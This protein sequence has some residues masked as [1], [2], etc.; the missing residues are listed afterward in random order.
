MKRQLI[1]GITSALM[2][3]GLAACGNNEA[4]S[5]NSTSSS[6]QKEWDGTMPTVEEKGEKTKLKF[7]DSGAP[8]DLKVQVVA[9]GSGATVEKTDTVIADYVG[10]VWGKDESFDSSFKRGAPTGFLLEKVIAGWT[11]GLAGQK[12]GSKVILV[13]PPDKGYGASGG[14][15]AAGIGADDVIA[16]YVEIK[17]AYGKDKGGDPHAKPETPLDQLPVEISGELGS[18][19]SVKV[20]AGQPQPTQRQL[21]VIARGS[22]EP[23]KD[24]G[25]TVYLQYGMSLWDNSTGEST[26]GITGPQAIPVTAGSPFELL[27]D[28]PVGSRVLITQPASEGANPPKSP[29]FAV[30]VDIVGQIPAGK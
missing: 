21:T 17:D 7:P 28:I 19:V 2:I 4:K 12:I 20:K 26:Y 8:K 5:S 10:Q 27:K 1:A 18:P 16:F 30:V 6:S 9:E 14:N 13:V 25:T 22:G 24:A 29:A 23:V 15:Q 3:F 11:E